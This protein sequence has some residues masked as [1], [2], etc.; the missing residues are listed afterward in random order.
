MKKLIQML[1]FETVSQKHKPQTEFNQLVWE[2]NYLKK[3]KKIDLIRF[4]FFILDRFKFKQPNRKKY[5][6]KM[7]FR[8]CV[9]MHEFWD[10]ITRYLTITLRFLNHCVNFCDAFL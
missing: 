6:F 8:C 3:L 2:K 4:L 1:L 9:R 5:K 10:M 7:L